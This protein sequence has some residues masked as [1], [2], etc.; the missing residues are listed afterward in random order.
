MDFSSS[1]ST[2]FF[3]FLFPHFIFIIYLHNN[4]MFFIIYYIFFIIIY[5]NLLTK[6]YILYYIFFIYPQIF[7]KHE[8]FESSYLT[9]GWS[10]FEWYWSFL[11]IKARKNMS[12][13]FALQKPFATNWDRTQGKYFATW[14]RAAS[15]KVSPT[16]V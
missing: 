4:Y 15:R 7:L 13:T 10:R 11:P 16:E 8:R 6:N 12:A 1:S 3:T 14:Q 5:P 2:N 9:T